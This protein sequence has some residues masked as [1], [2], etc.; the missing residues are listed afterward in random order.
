MVGELTESQLLRW[1]PLLPLIA[2][3]IHGVL[4]AVVRRS[5]P[6]GAVILAKRKID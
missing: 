2:A 5:L 6:R 1:I 3:A 4:I